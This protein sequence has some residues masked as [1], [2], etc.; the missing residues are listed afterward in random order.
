VQSVINSQPNIVILFADVMG[1]A[2]VQALNSKRGRIL[3]LNL[4]KLAQQ[5]VVFSDAHTTSSVCI[6][7]RYSL[8]TGRYT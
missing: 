7:S 5:G 4:D 6:A 2:E 8:L 3:T 1:Y